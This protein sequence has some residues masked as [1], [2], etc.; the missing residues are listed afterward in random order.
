MWEQIASNRARSAVVVTLIGVLLVA[1][2]AALGGAFSGAAEGALGGAGLAFVVWVVLWIVSATSGDR[3]LLSLAGASEIRKQD[4]PVLVNVV[5]E[6]TIAAHLPK[7]PRVYVVDDPSPNAFAT[8]LSPENAA[9]T[10]TTGLLKILD[11]D[12]LQGVVAHEIGHIKNRDVK[13]M[14]TAGIMIGTIV[15]VAEVG[16][17][18]IFYGGGRRSRSSSRDGGGQAIVLIVALVFM[19]LAPIFARLLYLALSRRREYLADASGALFTRYPEGLAS[20]LEKL[21]R[22]SRIPLASAGPATAPMYI[23][24]PRRMSAAGDQ[25]SLFATHPPIQERVR[26]LRGMAGRADLAAY[27]AAYRATKGASAIGEDSLSKSRVVAAR[28]ASPGAGATPAVE[29]QRAASDALLSAAGYSRVSC[30]SCGAVM[31]IPPTLAGDVTECLRCGEP[32]P[33]VHPSA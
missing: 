8:G 9:V 2:G 33:T 24:A 21:D 10:V 29:R 5:E 20:A 17:R 1:T 14:A 25:G 3:I 30:S 16:R 31:K 6:M 12:E 22:G 28:E 15:I 4:H 26:I 18:A 13:L 11:R 23:A 7:V 19:I 32:M 27:E